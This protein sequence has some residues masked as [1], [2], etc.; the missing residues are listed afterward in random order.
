MATS[1]HTLRHFVQVIA[2]NEVGFAQHFVLQPTAITI[3]MHLI[4]IGEPS[5]TDERFAE[6]MHARLGH[7]DLHP[8]PL[9]QHRLMGIAVG[10]GHTG[11]QRVALSVGK[12]T[13]LRRDAQH[14]TRQSAIMPVTIGVGR[15]RNHQYRLLALHYHRL[16]N[17][18][19]CGWQRRGYR[20][21]SLLLWGR[22]R[23][24]LGV[25]HLH[26][27]DGIAVVTRQRH[28]IREARQCRIDV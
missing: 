10:S 18:E 23:G 7:F 6:L 22:K 9:C 25:N 16:L 12:H 17:C 20:P 28:G 27:V 8:A 13:R 15:K 24:K 2:R 19:P 14:E 5:L 21:I 1:H 3:D 26:L 4:Y 11:G